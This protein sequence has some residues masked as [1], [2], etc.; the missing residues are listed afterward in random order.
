MTEQFQRLGV[1]GNWA[2]PYLTMDFKY[3]AAIA[4]ALGKFVEQGLV[5]K[6]K[7]PVHWCIH[8]RTALAEAEVEYEPHTSPS[9]YVE[10]PLLEE[11]ATELTARIPA[12]AG[13]QV[14]V[15]IWT[16]TPWTIPSNLAIAFHPDFDYAA[17]EVDGRAVIV[18]EALA[19]RVAAVTG[20]MF[21]PAIARMKGTALEH[22]RFEHPL[23]AR[24]S[25]GV[26]ADYVTLETGT[27]AVHTAP[28]HGVDDFN[29]GRKYGLE[30]YAPVGANG[31]FL[32]S[33]ELF[34]GEKVFD[35]N[36]KVEAALAE[37]GRLWHRESF[38]HSYPHCW[39]CQH[40][41][42]F[43]AT[44]QWFIRMDGLLADGRPLRQAALQ[45]VDEAVEW[46]PRWGRDRISNMLA[47]RP[48]W[49]ISRQR[50]WGVP[51]PAV[52]CADCGEA[53]LTTALVEQAASVFEQYGA[54]AWY[55]RPAD[56][57]VPKGLTC[58]S[59]GG[60]SFE[61]E[62]NILDVW[63]DSGS[64][65]EAVLSVRPDLTWPAQLYLEGSDQHRG[66]FQSSLLVGLGTRGRAP[67]GQVVT[68]G[69]VVAEDGR[70]MA[71]SRGNSIAPEDVIK[72]SGADI[73]RLW[74]AMSDYTQDVR[75]SQEI[76][77]R[78]SEAYRK[79]RNTLRYL[80]SNLYDFDPAIDRLKPEQL[81]AVDRYILAR[82]AEMAARIERA[83]D[84]YDYA[85]VFQAVNSFATVDVS[86][87]YADVSK[88]RLYTFAAQSP[89]RRSAQT[90]MYVM[91][92]GLARLAAPILPFTA[93]EIWGYLPGSREP[94]VHM[95]LFPPADELNALT[96]A[97]VLRRWEQL[98]GVRNE[99]LA[100]IEPLRKDKRIG[101][102][103]QASVMV[104]APSEAF[105]LL[106][107]HRE[108]L[109]MLFI[110]SRADL[111]RRDG[112]LAVKVTPADG[113]KCERCWRVVPRVSDDPERGGICSRCQDALAQPVSS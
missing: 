59:C 63:F 2:D 68:N 27:G 34:A 35:A 64:S 71:K 62:M 80:L 46:I 38:E 108:E 92:D 100:A 3:Q 55:E 29:T 39:R 20:K 40:P 110:V 82:Y 45:Q 28:G 106:E 72:K 70:K 33:V 81:A 10:F 65:H 61:R 52:D 16:T 32:E 93:D 36:P 15:L 8:C 21:G 30:I 103:M 95:A 50:A 58:P 91:A 98:I 49:C 112:P 105:E 26:L 77:A 84:E 94:S 6:G 25:V 89:D 78:A 53:V 22:V 42:I 57:F 19:P 7:K 23:Y 13:R 4:R 87:F 74:V 17:Y 37:R 86:A 101:S 99:V 113:V 9:I 1:L 85:A 88:D 11:G 111:E 48:D 83:Y 67:Y 24:T 14:S 97:A 47:A 5:Y 104:S 60:A 90:A 75:I 51:I 41:V 73:L 107:R 79:I 44:S 109:P 43:L 18:A 66:W 76:L 12:L 96:D 31:R 69:F 102:S 56:E 54:D